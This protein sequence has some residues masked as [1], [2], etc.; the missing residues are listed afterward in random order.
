MKQANEATNARTA[1]QAYTEHTSELTAMAEEIIAAKL[2]SNSKNANW[3]NVGS[4]AAARKAMVE[5][6]FTL[7]LITVAEAKE[8]HGVEI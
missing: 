5:V 6:M 1:A 7:G 3:C 2:S 4:A 8:K